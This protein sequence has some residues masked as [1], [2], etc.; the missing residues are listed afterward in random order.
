MKKNK[1]VYTPNV[2]NQWLELFR[3]NLQEKKMNIK[4]DMRRLNNIANAYN[5]TGGEVREMWKKKWYELV[6]I[7][8]TKLK[9][10]IH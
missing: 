7:I 1:K 3:K 9:R 4:S 2:Y 5:K 6:K 10:T 8:S